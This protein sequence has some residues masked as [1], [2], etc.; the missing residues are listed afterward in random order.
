MKMKKILSIVFILSFYPLGY[1][2]EPDSLLIQGNKA[3]SEGRYE[4]AINTYEKVLSQGLEASSLYYNLGNAYY[5]S[6]KLS[7]AIL[8]YE[9]ALRLDPRNEDAQFNL[10]F[11]NA[12]VADKIEELPVPFFTRWH[13]ALVRLLSSDRW[14]LISL[15]S[16][17]A[18]LVLFSLFLYLN[19][20]IARKI[21]FW[22][23]LLLL[24]LSIGSVVLARENKSMMEGENYAIVVSPSV[25]V[26]SSPDESG[27]DLFVIHDGTKVNVEDR[28]GEWK[29]VK[30]ANGSI[31]WVTGETIEII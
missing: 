17:L 3:Y 7:R 13:K 30:L 5:K 31:G 12:F 6:N 26:K 19:R 25:T 1:A 20:Y 11:A 23:A 24:I 8:N 16:F 15:A 10:E 4:E 18:F 21:S 27:T 9:R 14:A 2:T 22:T 29:K 28:V